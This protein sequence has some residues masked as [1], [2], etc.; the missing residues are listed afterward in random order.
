[1][2]QEPHFCPRLP[3]W[4]FLTK[5]N[6]PWQIVQSLSITIASEI[7]KLGNN[8][9]IE[10]GI[11]IHRTAVIEEGVILKAPLIVAEHCFIA[12]H[13]Y[14]RGGVYLGPNVSV[15][16][17]SEIKRSVLGKGSAL[18]HF[19]FIGDSIVGSDVNFE[20]GAVI[21]NHHNDRV[22]KE[23]YAMIDG[24]VMKTGVE[25]FGALIGDDTKIGAN[26]VLFPGTILQANSIVGRLELVNQIPP[27]AD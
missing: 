24:H 20:A 27:V 25:K 14:L 19:N 6:F 11:A 18:A 5:G 7:G 21:A 12:A 1:M 17:G 8:Y 9:Q 26:S 15:G 2:I 3:D 4:L 13:A 10:D 16:P 23:V 22:N